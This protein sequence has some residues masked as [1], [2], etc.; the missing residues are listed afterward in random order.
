MPVPV[1]ELGSYNY[2]PETKEN[3]DWADLPTIDLSLYGTPDGK[4]QLAQTLITALREKGFFYVKNFNISQERVNQQFAMGKHFFDLPLEEKMKYVPEGLDQGQFN[5]YIPAGRR[6]Y[7]SGIRDRIEIYNMPKFNGD[8]THNHPDL[9]AHRIDEVEQFARDLHSEVL[10][11]L[12]VLLAIALELPEDY[13]TKLHKYEVKSEDHLR[14]MKYGKYTPEENEKIKNKNWVRGHTDLGSFTLLFRQPVAALQIRSH[15][16]NEWKWAKPQDGTITVNSCDAL[17]FLTGGYVKS[18]IHRVVVPPK[19]QQ[20][21][22]RLGLLYFSRPHNDVKLNTVKDSPVLNREGSTQN[23]FESSGNGVPTME[24]WT[25]AKQ[26]WQRRKG[27]YTAEY[28]NE[29][30]LPGFQEQVY[31]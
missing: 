5:G 26:K 23:R 20:Q 15:T 19:D 17:S 30:I 1:P 8:F 16:T 22:D 12:H 27:A 10:D 14:Y 2:A 21:Y 28:Q 9:V 11:P 3:L 29:T 31:A 4:K 25:F 24:E 18:T 6:M 7:E 13:F